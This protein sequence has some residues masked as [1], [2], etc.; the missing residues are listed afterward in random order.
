[1]AGSSR[2][3]FLH[4]G[5]LDDQA[6]AQVEHGQ[7]EHAGPV[8]VAAGLGEGRRVAGDDDPLKAVG[9]VAPAGLVEVLTDRR[10]AA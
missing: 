1:M 10:A 9:H 2:V 4:G 8:R 3:P 7:A 5:L 6:V